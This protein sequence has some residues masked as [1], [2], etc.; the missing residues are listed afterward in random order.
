MIKNIYVYF[1]KEKNE[2]FMDRR[3]FMYTSW[4]ANKEKQKT[5][6]LLIICLLLF[7]I[8]LTPLQL[9]I[10]IT[11]QT[12]LNLLLCIHHKRDERY[13]ISN[14]F[15]KN[16]RLAKPFWKKNI[17]CY[18]VIVWFHHS[19]WKHC[20]YKMPCTHWNTHQNVFFCKER[21]KIQ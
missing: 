15:G 16:N 7:I 1:L 3:F 8:F 4:Y 6:I 11:F 2:Y 17:I 19:A 12:S 20:V 10:F 21:K 13:L 5:S 18:F 9:I 14:F